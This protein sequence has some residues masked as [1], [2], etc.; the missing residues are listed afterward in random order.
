MILLNLVDMVEQVEVLAHHLGFD[1]FAIEHRAFYS[2]VG[3]H[4]LY[5]D[6]VSVYTFLQDFIGEEVHLVCSSVDF[7]QLAEVALVAIG[8]IFLRDDVWKHSPA[9]LSHS[10]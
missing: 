4:L 5:I 8:V 2:D 10:K 3:Y 7:A 9:N 6:V 1:F